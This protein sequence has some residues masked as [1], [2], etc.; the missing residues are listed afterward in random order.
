MRRRRDLM[1]RHIRLGLA[2]RSVLVDFGVLATLEPSD[3]KYN[4]SKRS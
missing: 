3:G 4:F 2:D 1:R